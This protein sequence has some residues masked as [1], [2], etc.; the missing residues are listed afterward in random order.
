M[1]DVAKVTCSKSNA[2]APKDREPPRLYGWGEVE[3]RPH[4]PRIPGL[5]QRGRLKKAALAK[6]G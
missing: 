3:G 4:T 5:A 2:Q 6:A 1:R